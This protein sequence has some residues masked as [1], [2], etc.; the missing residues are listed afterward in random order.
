MTMKKSLNRKLKQFFRLCFFCLLL[1]SIVTVSVECVKILLYVYQQQQ[2]LERNRLLTLPLVLKVAKSL[3]ISATGSR[4]LS[5]T[6]SRSS[7]VV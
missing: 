2:L 4:S 7:S 1:F 5:A 3:V 6:G